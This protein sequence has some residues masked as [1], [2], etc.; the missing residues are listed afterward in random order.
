MKFIV[1]KDEFIHNLNAADS[2]INVKTPLA[3]LLNVYIEALEDGN[4]IIQSYNGDNGVKVESA[5]IVEVPGKVSLSSKKLLE[6]VRKMPDDKIVFESKED[7]ENDILIHPENKE[8]PL[9]NLIGV[10]AD[11]FPVFTEFN[12]ESYIRIAQETL[13]EQI[14]STEFAV[15]TDV[16]KIAFTGSYIEET[17]DGF[18][19]FVATDGKRLAVITREYEEKVGEVETGVIIPQ[20]IF[21][22]IHGSLGSGDVLFSVHNSQ[23]FFKI[24]NIYIF[25]NL[26][27][28]KFPKYKDVIPAEKINTAIVATDSFLTAI[29]TVSVMTDAET[30]KIKIEVGDKKAVISTTHLIYGV[31]KQ[32]IELE[33]SGT[34]ITI[35]I[36]YRS[37]YDFLKV[38]KSKEIE[39]TLNSQ[40]SPVLLKP[41]KDDNYMYI[42][43]PMKID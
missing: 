32:E 5:G 23:A 1:N 31:A 14:E 30:G 42:T 36:N 37:I 43:M 25:T 40:S 10:S 4:I 11:T 41:I 15:S 26:V 38:V 18:L 12:W 19:S 7:N 22:T 21:R 20:K 17:V 13:E 28:G 3:I 29:D 35:A 39:M 24:G 9:F 33:F 34:T 8:N 16:S 2:I 6:V 27:E